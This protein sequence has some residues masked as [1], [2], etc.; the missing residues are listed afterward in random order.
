M[1]L[2]G[3][4]VPIRFPVTHTFP[5]LSPPDRPSGEGAASED[6]GTSLHG[7]PPGVSNPSG[8]GAPHARPTE[9]GRVRTDGEKLAAAAA[10]V[11]D[12]GKKDGEELDGPAKKRGRI[13][14]GSAAALGEEKAANTAADEV[15]ADVAAP[16]PAVGGGTEPAAVKKDDPASEPQAAKEAE[17]SGP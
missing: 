14:D 8:G 7:G 10:E 11:G 9:E 13:H 12:G 2:P 6:A 17:T 3:G 1:L 4:P 16:V 15:S 5:I